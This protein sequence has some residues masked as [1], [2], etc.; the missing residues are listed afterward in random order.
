VLAGTETLRGNTEIKRVR[1]NIRLDFSTSKME[2]Q[3][4]FLLLK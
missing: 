4:I 2:K 1:R 3:R